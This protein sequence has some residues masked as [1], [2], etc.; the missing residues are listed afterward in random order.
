MLICDM[1]LVNYKKTQREKVMDYY[2]ATHTYHS[3][4]KKKEFLKRIKGRTNEMWVERMNNPTNSFH[5]RAR[6][7]QIFMGK[8]DF[9]FCNW[10]AESEQTIIDKL[11][12]L[13]AGEF[14]ITMAVKIKHPIA[15]TNEIKQMLT[16]LI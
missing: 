4:E 12:S 13:G 11:D 1:F 6:V 7:V 8:A 5:E 15:D 2:L 3:D 10:Y 16:N 9:F 14:V